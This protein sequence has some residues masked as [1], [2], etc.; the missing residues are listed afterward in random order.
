MQFYCKKE[1]GKKYK[2]TDK[3]RNKQLEYWHSKGK[4]LKEGKRLR[5]R[6][7]ILRKYNFTCQYCG[8][9][10]PEVILE[11]DHKFPKSKGGLNKIENYIVACRECNIGKGDIILKELLKL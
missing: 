11:V 1:C 9:K 4:F 3:Y 6:F 2:K 10:S 7:E 8:R 5:L